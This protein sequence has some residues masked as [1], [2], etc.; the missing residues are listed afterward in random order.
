MFLIRQSRRALGVAIA[1]VCLFP[2][3]A[4]GQFFEES[5]VWEGTDSIGREVA[6]YIS[7]EGR[8]YSQYPLLTS[9]TGDGHG[10][11]SIDPAD[12]TIRFRSLSEVGIASAVDLVSRKYTLAKG[13]DGAVVLT[14]GGTGHRLTLKPTDDTPDFL[15]EEIIEYSIQ[16]PKNVFYDLSDPVGHGLNLDS[17][18]PH[19]V[20]FSDSTGAEISLEGADKELFRVQRNEATGHTLVYLAEPLQAKADQSGYELS[21]VRQPGLAKRPIVAASTERF[22]IHVN[23]GDS[24]V[25][26]LPP[27]FAL[28][29]IFLGPPPDAP[30]KIR[31]FGANNYTLSVEDSADLA[32]WKT[33]G[34]LDGEGETVEWIDSRNNRPSALYYRIRLAP[35]ELASPGV[36]DFSGGKPLDPD[37]KLAQDLAKTVLARLNTDG[38]IVTGSTVESIVLLLP[39]IFG[40]QYLVELRGNNEQQQPVS[41]YAE[42]AETGVQKTH[43][44]TKLNVDDRWEMLRRMESIELDDGLSLAPTVS[45]ADR[46]AASA[47]FALADLNERTGKNWSL[48]EV[49]SSLETGAETDH[50]VLTLAT[51]EGETATVFVEVGID[52]ETN[53]SEVLTAFTQSE[54]GVTVVPLESGAPSEAGDAEFAS[55]ILG[56]VELSSVKTD[57]PLA[58]RLAGFVLEQEPA[59]E[60]GLKLKRIVAVTEAKAAD[61]TSYFIELL[62]TTEAGEA[63]LVQAH[64]S[65]LDDGKLGLLSFQIVEGE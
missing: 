22:L 3:L 11:W 24:V 59:T 20:V 32:N 65:E 18:T 26:G 30:L 10:V 36:F 60:S 8:F 5:A 4:K 6:L 21:I 25:G 54:L 29:P 9:A 35:K 40:P 28:P 14:A 27:I 42:L 37:G 41:V 17:W 1:L 19:G 46:S 50:L 39:P 43:F 2:S 64:L 13:Q 16:V 48:V 58:K 63:V 31:F 7:P 51:P 62:G 55:I 33:V 57:S 53:Q 15:P 56:S 47:E 52:Q 44:V 61:A 23:P 38:R 49:I 12:N 34:S 45:N